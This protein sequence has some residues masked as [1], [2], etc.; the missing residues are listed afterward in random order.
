MAIG[1]DVDGY[2]TAPYTGPNVGYFIGTIDEIRIYNRALTDEEI[3]SLYHNY[4]TAVDVP[5]NTIPESFKVYQN[6]PNPFNPVTKISWQ[7]PVSS[8]QTLRI[9][10]ILGREVATLIDE[11][12][13]AGRY[14]ISFNG[15]D[16][17]SGVYF[18]QL[19]SGE[20][21]AVKKMILLK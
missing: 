8:Q 3:D 6:Y 10:D 9:Y 14:E 5:K 21:T 11:F 1:V 19:K 20:Y 18:Y 12:K 2:G 17:P 16:L 13:P 15:A 7:S 4:I